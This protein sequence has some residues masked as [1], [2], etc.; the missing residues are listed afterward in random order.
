[1]SV[2]D[3]YYLPTAHFVIKTTH[4][5][6]NSCSFNSYQC[7]FV[8]FE[9]GLFWLRWGFCIN[10]DKCQQLNRVLQGEGTHLWMDLIVGITLTSRLSHYLGWNNVEQMLDNYWS[11]VRWN[12]H[13]R[14]ICC[15]LES[16]SVILLD[17]T[18][19]QPLDVPSPAARLNNLAVHGQSH[20]SI[21]FVFSSD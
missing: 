5:L 19:S 16:S 17:Y 8:H 12:R 7:R 20:S 21:W 6:P 11:G 1:M 2:I 13:C 14:G 9:N 4:I 15:D 18:L 10:L 3:F